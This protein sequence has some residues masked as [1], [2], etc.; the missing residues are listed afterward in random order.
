MSG[1]LSIDTSNSNVRFIIKKLVVLKVKGI[2][3]G[4]DGAIYF[5]EYHLEDSFFDVSLTPVTV[6][7]GNS[8]WDERL[9]SW[10]FF[11]VKKYPTIRFNSI[12]VKKLNNL[13]HVKGILKMLEKSVELTIP[14]EYKNGVFSGI[15]SLDRMDYDLGKKFPPIFIGKNIEITVNCVTLNNS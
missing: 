6:K 14:L 5:D 2:L 3:S 1:F 4:F 12:T 15:F 8:K 9:R 10:D 7:T 13:F 11:Y